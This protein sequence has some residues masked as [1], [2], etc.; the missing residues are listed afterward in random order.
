MRP[1]R[2]LYLIMITILLLPAE[3][4]AVPN[5]NAT[6]FQLNHSTPAEIDISFTLPEWNIQESAN[7]RQQVKVKDS[8]CLFIDE[9]ETMPVFSTMVAIPDRGGVNLQV[10]TSMQSTINGFTAAFET[11]LIREQQQGRFL[12]ELYPANNIA[13]SEPKIL[14]DFRVVTINVYPFQ[15]NRKHK[16]LL[17]SETLNI[18]LTFT[19]TGSINE[20][21]PS[22]YISRSFDSIY[23]GLILNYDSLLPTRESNYRN[24]VMLVIY[25]NYS[26]AI[27][28]AKINEYI[29]WKKQ[30][31]FI[32]N[33][34]STG[35]TGSS[36]TNIKNY[37][38]TAYDNPATRPDYIV[39]IGD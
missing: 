28:T 39:L 32:V 6:A 18:K 31:G 23:R 13:A 22:P 20:L 5:T 4:S 36:N 24:P 27:Y 35:V 21:N 37:I 11:Q 12:E 9:E 2:Y 25:G 8:P 10:V 33:A 16:Q 15:Y 19:D 26:D 3:L 1:Y 30:R 34:V 29:S 17:I 7:N 14:R 38:Q